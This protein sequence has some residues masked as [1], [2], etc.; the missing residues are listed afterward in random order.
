MAVTECERVPYRN[1]I[2]YEAL[3]ISWQVEDRTAG[4][5]TALVV[6]FIRFSYRPSC[7]EHYKHER[8][9]RRAVIC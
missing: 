5:A 2:F 6:R 4:G 1:A 3:S 9:H 7:K 8:Y